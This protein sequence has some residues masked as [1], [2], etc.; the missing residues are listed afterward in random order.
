MCFAAHWLLYSAVRCNYDYLVHVTHVGWVT[1]SRPTV[2]THWLLYSV[3]RCNSDYLVH[4]THVGWVTCSRPTVNIFLF[5]YKKK[6]KKKK[7][8][9][10][11]GTCM[12]SKLGSTKLSKT[13]HQKYMWFPSKTR[14]VFSGGLMQCTFPLVNGKHQITSSTPRYAWK[15]SK[16]RLYTCTGT[17]RHDFLFNAQRGQIGNDFH[18]DLESLVRCNGRLNRNSIL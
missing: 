13:Q 16:A 7:R 12:W 11:F 9:S 6:K 3:V 15:L 4:V 8:S 10:H 1:C 5:G 2:A 14:H 18:L 17:K